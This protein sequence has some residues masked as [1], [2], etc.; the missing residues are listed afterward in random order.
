MSTLL[1][2]CMIGPSEPCEAFQALQV[3]LAKR[4]SPAVTL[5]M[6]NFREGILQ[7]RVAEAVAAERERCARIAENY[8]GDAAKAIAAAI[9]KGEP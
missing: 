6:D 8:Y 2:D 9:R 3:E 4:Q 7:R 1:P 5:A